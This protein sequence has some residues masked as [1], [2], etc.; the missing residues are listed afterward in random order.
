MQNSASFSL[1][2][3]SQTFCRLYLPKRRELNWI[4]PVS[5][6]VFLLFFLYTFDGK[7]AFLELSDVFW[8]SLHTCPQYVRVSLPGSE[9]LFFVMDSQCCTGRRNFSDK[10][11]RSHGKQWLSGRRSWIWFCILWRDSWRS[12]ALRLYALCCKR[13]FS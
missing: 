3:V 2:P 8:D 13:T 6:R 12:R 4:K 7:V 10:L 1:F 5:L 9:L 11:C